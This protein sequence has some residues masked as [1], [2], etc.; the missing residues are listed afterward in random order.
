M[1]HSK[2]LAD[3]ETQEQVGVGSGLGMFMPGSTASNLSFPISHSRTAVLP[4]NDASKSSPITPSQLLAAHTTA[5]TMSS[6]GSLSLAGLFSGLATSSVSPVHS[7]VI[8]SVAPSSTW[9]AYALTGHLGTDK[10]EL[11]SS[12]DFE[13]DPV[14][15][16]QLD[17]WTNLANYQDTMNVEF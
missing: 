2:D 14:E 11:A 1:D 13:F 8:T 3:S 9:N 7:A 17:E 16:L 6:T 4:S 10:D 12:M 15:Q 5:Q